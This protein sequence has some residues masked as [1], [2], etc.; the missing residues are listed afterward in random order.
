MAQALKQLRSAAA[1]AQ[2]LLLDLAL[3]FVSA[4]SGTSV[5]VFKGWR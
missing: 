5:K 4:R 1:R 3:H 2:P